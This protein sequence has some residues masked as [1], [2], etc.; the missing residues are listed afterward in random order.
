MRM[1]LL[2][3]LAGLLSPPGKRDTEGYWLHVQCDRCGEVI[4][5]RVDMRNDLSAE[6]GE[7]EGQEAGSEISSYFSRKVLIGQR[8][9]Q[10]IEVELTF[11]ER[12]QPIDRQ[13][14]G[15][16]FV[17]EGQDLSAQE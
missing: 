17:E 12:R 2:K 3:K 14:K 13:V 15:G 16:Q 10:P 8:C 4:R 5:A 6:Y 9:Y 1:S 7:T 11:D